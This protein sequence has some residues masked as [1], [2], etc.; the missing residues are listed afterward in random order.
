MG[1]ELM[2]NFSEPNIISLSMVNQ[3]LT[4]GRLILSGSA[5]ATPVVIGRSG[6]G[7]LK[8]EGD[9]KSPKG[10][11]HPLM[12]YY[13][14]DKVRRPLSALP[15]A[16]LEPDDGWCDAPENR[17]YNRFIKRPYPASSESLWR[18]DDMYDLI[19][20][21]DHNQRPRVK[22]RGSAIF[23]HLAKPENSPTEGCIAMNKTNL[24]RLI[25]V[26]TRQTR[27]II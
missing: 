23:M 27:I 21:L 10:I 6:T 17:N 14:T 9:G 19:V 25:T 7:A 22:H 2:S 26:M 13:R 15:I 12:V 3:S 24:L 5:I 8:R 4:K 20:V 1:V 11:W 16:P 18:E